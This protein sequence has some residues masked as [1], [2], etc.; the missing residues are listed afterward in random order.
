MAKTFSTSFLDDDDAPALGLSPV[1]QIWDVDTNAFV[2]SDTMVEVAGGKGG[3]GARTTMV[4]ATE[5]A[6]VYEVVEGQRKA[7]GKAIGE[8]VD[9]LPVKEVNM[10][11]A[12]DEID[13]ILRITTVDADLP[14]V[15]KLADV[16]ARVLLAHVADELIREPMLKH[17][18]IEAML[19]YDLENKT[20]YADSV[21]AWLDAVG[22]IALAAESLFIHANT[23]R[24]RLRRVKDLFNIS[25]DNPD[26]RLAVWMQLRLVMR[27]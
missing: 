27:D 26:D 17:P 18:G 15:A 14:A 6:K 3:R 24:Y 16:H 20:N 23:L 21:T 12:F 7:V 13:D 8:A 1:I 10:K 22:D 19:A 11:P 2:L 25:L 9:N 4:P 5:Y